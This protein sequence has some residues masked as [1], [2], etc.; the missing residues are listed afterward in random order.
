MGTTE[1]AGR[2][3]V[4]R[5]DT[6]W[7]EQDRA[8]SNFVRLVSHEV[9]APIS[10]VIGFLELI[11]NGYVDEKS[12]QLE[13]LTR[14]RKRLDGLLSMVKDLLSI[15]RMENSGTYLRFEE[16]AIDKIVEEVA[17]SLES[18]AQEKEVT[19]IRN[20]EPVKNLSADETSMFQL[21]TNLISNGI[22]Y[23][24]QGGTL[25]LGIAPS[26]SGVEIVVRD[27]GLGIPPDSLARIWEPFFR[28]QTEEIKSITGT[29][30]GLSIV[31]RIID[32][33]RGKIDVQSEIGVGTTFRIWMPV[34]E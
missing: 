26:G 23:N 7:A 13:Y 15:T 27:T 9:K 5:D 33:H 21:F 28:V 20:F 30:L 17:A 18:S 25:T 14:S 24:K 19:V 34:V 3:L 29:G 2:T 6:R 11:L 12:K 16:L 31:R 32:S 10:A 22:K 4:I 1:E 8:K